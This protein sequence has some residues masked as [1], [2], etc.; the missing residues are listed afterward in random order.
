[1][2]RLAVPVV[3]AELGWMAMG[4]VDTIMVGR[5]GPVAIGAV[6]LGGILVDTTALFGLGLTF[7]LDTMV[8]QSYG[9]G[10][11]RECHRWL[12]NGV[13]LA[14]LASPVL[15]FVALASIPGLAWFDVHPAVVNDAGPYIRAVAFSIPSL[16][17]Y[18]GLRRYLQ[19]VNLVRPVMIALLSANL[20]NI[21]V[22]WLLIFGNW[23]MPRLGAEGAGWATCLSRIYLCVFLVAIVRWS[24]PDV[25]AIPRRV[26]WSRLRNLIRLGLPAAGQIAL[27]VGVF[28]LASALAG[29]L[30]PVSLAAHAI[31]LRIA[32]TTFMVPLGVSSAGAVRVGQAIGRRDPH[33]AAVAG[34]TA[35]AI[36][37]GF[38]M[39]AGLV[40]WLAP[41]LIIRAFTSDA[42]LVAATSA[43][44]FVA[45]IFQLFDGMQVVATGVLRGAGDTMTPMLSN[46]CGHWL[47]GLPVGYALC[48]RYGWG[49][50]GLW[51]GLSA[52]L[53]AVGVVLLL[54]WRRMVHRLTE[55]LPVSQVA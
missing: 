33:G 29:R 12:L 16:L 17:L 20:V 24:E 25:L 41:E 21:F 27:E 50:Q 32:G 5:V 15:M 36:G 34:W 37:T 23:G 3:L 13:Y 19:A 46:L 54:M 10:N 51:V 47:M 39:A 38:M 30:D 28:A 11:R 45:A 26:E 7:G 22:N 1:M 6:M 14:L 31:A 4:I 48:F 2:V 35:L 43:L 55:A 8:S 44:V 49:V 40:L 9:A 52:G 53:I 18:S 42:D